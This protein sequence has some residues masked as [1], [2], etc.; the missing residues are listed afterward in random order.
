MKSILKI[1]IT[2]TLILTMMLSLA[3]CTISEYIY[4]ILYSSSGNDSLDEGNNDTGKENEKD[5]R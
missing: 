1:F 4:S 3:S 5:K 2:V